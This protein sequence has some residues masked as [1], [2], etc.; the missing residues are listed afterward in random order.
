VDRHPDRG[1]GDEDQRPGDQVEGRG[2]VEAD[3]AQCAQRSEGQEPEDEQRE[4][5][6]DPAA[7][8]IPGALCAIGVVGATGQVGAVVRRLLAERDF[9]VAGIRFFA[10]YRSAGTT[11]PWKGENI[12][13]ED[14]ATA[15][16]VLVARP[17]DGLLGRGR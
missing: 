14:A 5:P 2:E 1:Q 15:A 10:S 9:P 16:P 11:L 17:I 12:V 8:Q 13:V 4:G 3:D 6:T 7:S